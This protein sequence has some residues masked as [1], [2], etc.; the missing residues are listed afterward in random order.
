MC[1]SILDEVFEV[2]K[3]KDKGGAKEFDWFLLQAKKVHRHDDWRR[4]LFSVCSDILNSI[5]KLRNMFK[6]NVDAHCEWFLYEPHHQPSFYRYEWL[7]QE[8]CCEMILSR[9]RSSKSQ[10]HY[11]GISKVPIHNLNPL[12]FKVDYYAD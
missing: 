9:D 4:V 12:N 2:F 7:L 10:S 1:L 5:I 8:K 6:G 3:I 11:T